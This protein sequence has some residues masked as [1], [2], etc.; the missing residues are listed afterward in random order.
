MCTIY[1]QWSQYIFI[2][3]YCFNILGEKFLL[4]IHSGLMEKYHQV[5][6]KMKCRYLL[7]GNHNKTYFKIGLVIF[8]QFI[9]IDNILY[10]ILWSTRVMSSCFKDDKI[11]VELWFLIMFEVDPKYGALFGDTQFDKVFWGQSLLI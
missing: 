8:Y 6:K 5:M 2:F 7:Q 9:K 1:M 10:C 4:I 3:I 11:V